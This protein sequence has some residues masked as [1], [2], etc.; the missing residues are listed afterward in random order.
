LHLQQ[1]GGPRE[2]GRADKHH[3]PLSDAG[4][5]ATGGRR[6]KAFGVRDRSDR[7]H[8]EGVGYLLKERVSDVES[9]IDAVGRVAR[10]G[11]A[12][13]LEVVER[14]PGRRQRDRPLDGL[15]P[16]EYD[17]LAIGSIGRTRLVPRFGARRLVTLGMALDAAAMLPLTGVTVHA[18]DVTHV[19]QG[20][21]VM[22]IG[23][24]LTWRRP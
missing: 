8:A 11:S 22:G 24:G 12:L 13:D 20:L 5:Q 23:L 1:S 10:G 2:H 15:S 4:E 21:L 7:E 16:R 17:V 18:S 3:R 6:V 9:F 19:P 14:M